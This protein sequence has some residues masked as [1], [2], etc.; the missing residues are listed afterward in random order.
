MEKGE[1]LKPEKD[2][3]AKRKSCILSA[4][5]ETLILITKF[6]IAKWIHGSFSF[7]LQNIF[8]IMFLLNKMNWQILLLKLKIWRTKSIILNEKCQNELYKL[9][10]CFSA[11]MKIMKYI[12]QYDTLLESGNRFMACYIDSAI[13]FIT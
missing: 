6:Y 5:W 9:Y 12:L 8:F 13:Y 11:E 10:Y 3:Q 4:K 1:N 2:S 7:K